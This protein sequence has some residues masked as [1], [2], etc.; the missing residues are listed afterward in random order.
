[1]ETD[2]DGAHVWMTGRRRKGQQRKWRNK[3]RGERIYF[4]E[5]CFKDGG[6]TQREV[7]PGEGPLAVRTKL[8]T[9]APALGPFCPPPTPLPSGASWAPGSWDFRI[10]P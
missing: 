9:R 7:R 5:D 4:R 8:Y 3:G 10:P 6:L 1:M 2:E